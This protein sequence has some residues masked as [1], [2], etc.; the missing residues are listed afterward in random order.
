VKTIFVGLTGASGVTYGLRL[1]T[2]LLEQGHRVLLCASEWGAK[3]VAQE[4]GIPWREWTDRWKQDHPE[5]FRLLDEGALGSGPAS[6]SFLLD[7]TVVVPASVSTIGHLATGVVT[8]LIHRAGAV[9]LKEW[10]PLVLVPRETPLSLIDLR[11]LTTLA[12]AGAVILPAMPGFYHRPQTLEALV[13]QLVGKILD[14]LGVE[15]NLSPRWN[16][17][18]W[19][20]HED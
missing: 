16:P 7:A 15:H 10:R 4:S 6:G 11:N 14:R 13:D 8:N 2:V 20:Q 19:S 1:V 9:A 17:T 3:V 18:S 12:E 5:T